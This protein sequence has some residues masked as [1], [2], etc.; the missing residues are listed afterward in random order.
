MV[1]FRIG[2]EDAESMAKEMA[3]T[4][5]EFDL[6]NVEKF[7]G[8]LKLMINGTASKP[9]NMATYGL[10][11][12]TDRQR[13]IAEA[14]RQLSRL[15]YGRP[16]GEVEAEVLEASMVADMMSAGPGGIERTL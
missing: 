8:F 9:F 15:K 13:E 4:F 3:P 10:A 7:N 6:V 16:R 11:K 2:V 5:N 14:I 12:P 1:C